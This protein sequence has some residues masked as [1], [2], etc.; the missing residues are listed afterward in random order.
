MW[1][2]NRFEVQ[3]EETVDFLRA[4]GMQDVPLGVI[5][6]SGF[7]SF[8]EKV[9][10]GCSLPYSAIPHFPYSTVQG[11][12]GKLIQ[13]RVGRR[14]LLVMQGRLHYYEG[15]SPTQV[16]FP[17]WV[18]ERLGVKVLIVSTAAG[19]LSPSFQPGDL[20]LITDQISLMGKS[21]LWG[22]TY[23]RV[24]MKDCY[25]PSLRGLA[26]KVAQELRIPLREGVLAFFPGPTY[27]TPAEAELA[28]RMGAHAVSMSTAPEV[29][30]ARALGIEV[31]GISCISNILQ[32]NRRR[33][34]D[35]KEVLTTVQ[36][37]GERFTLLLLGLIECL[38]V[39]K[40]RTNHP[41]LG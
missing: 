16:T 10:Q 37:A 31:L 22:L 36:R 4:K 14:L 25:S 5:L 9:D 19:G 8:I 27:E 13:G 18:M 11:H 28:R 33:N 21:P 3:L 41:V 24:D 6:G 39:E 12:L 23:L 17:I 20:M 2:R 35:H 29:I 40:D 7:D 34:L 26:Q 15:Y 38:K 30:V 1:K 32:P